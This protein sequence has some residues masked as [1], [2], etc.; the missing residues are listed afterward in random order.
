MYLMMFGDVDPVVVKCLGE[1]LGSW[2]CYTVD[3]VEAFLFSLEYKST[4][5]IPVVEI[6]IIW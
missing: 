2:Y 1:F 4:S 6:F 5:N 3:G